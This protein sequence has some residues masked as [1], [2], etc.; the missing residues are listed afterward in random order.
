MRKRVGLCAVEHGHRHVE[1]ARHA[2]AACST[3]EVSLCTT[4]VANCTPPIL[5]LLAQSLLLDLVLVMCTVS[6]STA[7]D[8]EGLVAL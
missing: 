8:K 7:T 2:H 6:G 4:M 5:P 1:G 3:H